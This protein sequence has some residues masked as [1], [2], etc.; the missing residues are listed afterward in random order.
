MK[1]CHCTSGLAQCITV[2]E[3]RGVGLTWIGGTGVKRCL[4]KSYTTVGF[5]V[6][7]LCAM[8]SVASSAVICPV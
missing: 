8:R 6:D 4:Y 5:D 1:A 3:R 7:G 2:R